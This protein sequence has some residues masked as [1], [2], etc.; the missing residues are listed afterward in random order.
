M[1]KV[2]Y[3]L[4][5]NL[6]L[7]V[8][9][10][11]VL[12][13][14]KIVEKN[15]IA[16]FEILLCYWSKSELLKTKAEIENKYL[17]IHFLKIF[18]PIFFLDSLNA[19]LL[20]NKIKEIGSF[21]YIH[22]RTDYCVKILK[23]IDKKTKV[24]WDCRGDSA[25]E[26]YHNPREKFIILK[27]MILEK[28]FSDAGKIATKII[29]VS[30]YLRDKFKRLNKNFPKKN[31]FLI[32]SLASSDLFFFNKDIRQRMRKHLKIKNNTRVFIYV[33][34]MQ[35]YQKFPQTLNFFNDL[36]KYDKNIIL[37]VLTNNTS[38][39]M[40]YI[41]DNDSI[42]LKNVKFEE[43]NNYL[44]ASDFG[45]LIRD[46]N[47]ANNAGSPTKFAEYA[48]TGL[49]IISSPSV[50]DYFNLNSKIKNIYDYKKFILKKNLVYDRDK[51]ANFYKLKLSRESF[52]NTFQ[53]L[54]E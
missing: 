28:R 27:R 51:V 12:A 17:K 39:A 9:K 13:H 41:K 26:L 38:E 35:N 31:I 10:S 54:Y 34:G 37:L 23:M 29:F 4:T 43:V 21:T 19:Y 50:S 20:K 3:V 24:L 11:Q 32:P 25:A 16:K 33:G 18:R 30:M 45:L 22:A 53:R 47:Y 44:N 8:I 7:G 40:S 15:K 49:Q 36:K 52:T 46:D 6:S 5:E 48:M 14:I 2:L 1:K 42:I